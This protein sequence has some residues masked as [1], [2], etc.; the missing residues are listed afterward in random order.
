M[1]VMGLTTQYFH[2]KLLCQKPISRQLKWGVQNVPIKK[3]KVL[4]VITLYFRKFRFSSRTLY[5]WLI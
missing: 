1:K 3:N 4:P 2:T 5:K